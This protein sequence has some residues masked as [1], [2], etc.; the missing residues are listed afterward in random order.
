MLE[1]KRDQFYC[2]DGTDK[3]GNELDLKIYG[4]YDSHMSRTISIVYRPCIPRQQGP[5]NST[6]KCLIQ[7]MNNQT[8]LDEKLSESKEYVGNTG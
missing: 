2:L 3:F 5:Q 4:K 8:M 6:E 1:K 7:D